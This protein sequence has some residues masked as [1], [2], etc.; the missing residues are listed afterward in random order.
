MRDWVKERKRKVTSRGKSG[1]RN[2]INE[3]CDWVCVQFLLDRISS[4]EME[5][6]NKR[7]CKSVKG[8]ERKKGE[9]YQR[10]YQ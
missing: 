4:C 10:W 7:K 3:K 9:K 8:G 2:E 1:R 6:K 5:R